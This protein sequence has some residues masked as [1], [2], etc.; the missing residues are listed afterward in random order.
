MQIGK[1][2]IQYFN[3]ETTINLR[4][5]TIVCLTLTQ[6]VHIQLYTQVG[7]AARLHCLALSS[8]FVKQ[9]RNI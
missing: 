8:E 9:L 3:R 4:W 7:T 5:E 1:V 6:S 2:R